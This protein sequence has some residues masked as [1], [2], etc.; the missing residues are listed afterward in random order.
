MENKSILERARK[1]EDN[2]IKNILKEEKQEFHLCAPIGWINDPNGFSTFKGEYHLFYQYHPYGTYWGPMH[3]GHSKSKDFIKWEQLPIA[4]APDEKYDESGCFSGSAVE[5]DGKHILMYTGVLEKVDNSGSKIVR[6]T[7]CIAVG[8]G[9]NYEKLDCNPVITH[10]QLPEGS[11]KEDFRDPK[12]WKEGEWF[13]SVIASR[14]ADNSGQ[15]LMYKSKDLKVWKLVTVLDKS[16][17]KIGTMWECPDFFELD[18]EHVLIISPMEVRANEKG[19]HNGHNSIFITGNYNKE[20][21]VFERRTEELI[22]GGLDFYAPQTLETKDG[23]RIMIGWMQ[24]WENKIVPDEFKWCGMMTIPRELNLREG[25]VIQDP[26]R[27]LSNYHKN[28]IK[29]ENIEVQDEISLE[30]IS[31]RIL[32]LTLEIDA[33]DSKEFIIRLAKDDEHETLINYNPIHNLLTFDRSYS[34]KLKNMIHKRDMRIKGSESKI[35]LRIVLDRYSAE[36]FIND[37]QQ[38][39]TSTFYTPLDAQNITFESNGKSIINVEKHDIVL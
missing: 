11:S 27:E 37:G 28:T 31:G 15:I 25:M 16:E 17:N 8:D 10:E 22:D 36:I 14:A 2:N 1:Y 6:Q 33:K 21:N 24:T 9:I 4:I 20:N 19:Y 23:R 5:A 7:Q 35:K 18:K 38:T 3:W 39:M 34:G 12:I 32:D 29:Y 13:Y 26:V 30:G